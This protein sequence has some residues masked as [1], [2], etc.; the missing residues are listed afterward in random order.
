MR[1]DHCRSQHVGHL[2][3][4]SAQPAVYNSNQIQIDTKEA[5]PNPLSFESDRV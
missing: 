4:D 3:I 5:C 1:Q 2:N